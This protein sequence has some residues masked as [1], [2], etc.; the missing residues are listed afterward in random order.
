M[1]LKREPQE[2]RIYYSRFRIAITLLW[3]SGLR[4]SE[5]LNFTQND[6]QSILKNHS[7]QIFQTKN[8][9]FRLIFF[10]QETLKQLTK[11]DNDF[12]V[13]FQNHQIIAGNANT[14]IWRDFINRNL[15]KKTRLFNKNIKSHS[16]RVN[17][18]TSLLEHTS[19]QVVKDLVG[20]ANADTTLRYNRYQPNKQQLAQ[21]LNKVFPLKD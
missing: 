21:L 9:K 14:K 11:L 15:K 8:K 7:L 2:K 4:V 16:F 6:R 18:I 17:Y 5:I 1:N 10:S 13:V 3:A 12:K 20:H 19:L